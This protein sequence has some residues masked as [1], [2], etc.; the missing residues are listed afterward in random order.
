MGVLIDNA[1]LTGGMMERFF[2]NLPSFAYR[3]TEDEKGKLRW[4]AMIDGEE[5]VETSEP[6]ASR[7][8]RFKAFLFRIFPEGQL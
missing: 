8:L 1:D 4:T 3:V 6:Q 7:W 2:Q 5:V